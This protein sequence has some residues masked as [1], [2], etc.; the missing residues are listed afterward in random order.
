M[1]L[2][3]AIAQARRTNERRLEKTLGLDP[4]QFSD[5]DRI[6]IG[7]LQLF[8]R[9]NGVSAEP[10]IPP[11]AIAAWLETLAAP[12]LLD[13]CSA[14]EKYHDYRSAPNSVAT[15]AVRTVLSRRL[16]ILPP[17]SWRKDELLLWAELG[18]ELRAT[19]ARREADRDQA[20]RRL[21]NKAAEGIGVRPEL[22]KFLTRTRDKQK[23]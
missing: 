13:I 3:D 22:R 5:A 10:P 20:L 11:A 7:Q 17:R 18:P 21:Q 19:I 23:D 2:T 4:V 16:T 8:C 14:I 12:D 1:S 9:S 6:W 15:R